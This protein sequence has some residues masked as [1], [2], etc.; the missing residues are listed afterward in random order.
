MRVFE[1]D[2]K[3]YDADPG[4]YVYEKCRVPTAHAAR[5]APSDPDGA[6]EARRLF[7]AARVIQR[8]ARYFI[9]REYNFSNSYLTD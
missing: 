7:S 6:D 3:P 8:L 9:E 2:R 5:D 1:E 4:T